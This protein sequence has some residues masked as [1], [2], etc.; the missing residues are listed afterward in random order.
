[1]KLGKGLDDGEGSDNVFIAL[2]ASA[3]AVVTR[4][5]GLEVL[6]GCQNL[7]AVG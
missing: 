4:R 3:L 7:L 1:M 6:Q 2:A 5:G